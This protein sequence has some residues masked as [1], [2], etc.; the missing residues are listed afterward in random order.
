MRSRPLPRPFA[1]EGGTRR[2]P[3]R[4][5][6]WE[7]EGGP[8]LRLTLPREPSRTSPILQATLTLPTHDPRFAG[9]ALGPPLSRQRERGISFSILSERYGT[10]PNYRRSR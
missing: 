1:G 10:N 8:D 2:T 4:G 6:R 7:G 5:G 3:H 9:Q